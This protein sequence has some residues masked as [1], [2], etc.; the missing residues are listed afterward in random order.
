MAADCT[1]VM[2][3]LPPSNVG[4]ACM[5]CVLPAGMRV[6]STRARR[7]GRCVRG[8][9]GGVTGPSSWREARQHLMGT[10]TCMHGL[11]WFSHFNCLDVY[12]LVI[13]CAKLAHHACMSNSLLRCKPQAR[14]G[15]RAVCTTAAWQLAMIRCY[16]NKT[17]TTCAGHHCM[18]HTMTTASKHLA[19]V[20]QACPP[21]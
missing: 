10:S 9:T 3:L 20:C 6:A 16:P 11:H 17:C 5:R 19:S 13:T 14:G 1:P 4:L 8:W 7:P 21:D 2:L 12:L 18:R 15:G